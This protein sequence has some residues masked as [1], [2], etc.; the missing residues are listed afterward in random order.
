M[1]INKVKE[2]VKKEKFN[3]KQTRLMK[4]DQRIYDHKPVFVKLVNNFDKKV[5]YKKF[6]F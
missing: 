6:I 2:F 5:R 4:G 3:L 1:N